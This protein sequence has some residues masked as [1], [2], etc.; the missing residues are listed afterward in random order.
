MSLSTQQQAKL[1]QINQAKQIHHSELIQSLWGGYGELLRVHFKQGLRSSLVVKNIRYPEQVEHPRGWNTQGSHQRKVR[2]YQVELAWYQHF[3]A[4]CDNNCYVPSLLDLSAD[5]NQQWLVLEDLH[6]LGFNQVKQQVSAEQALVCV[7]WLAYFHARFLQAPAAQ[8]WQQGSYWH[9]AT[10]PDEL[11]AMEDSPLKQAA[12]VIDQQLQNSDYHCLIHGDAK[13]ANFCFNQEM[14][15]AAA[16]DFQYVGKGCGIQDLALFM[17]S[18][19]SEQQCFEQQDHFLEIYFHQL[20]Q[21]ISHYKISLVNVAE[22]ERQWRAL[23]PFAWADFQRF[24]LGWSPDHWK[25]NSYSEQQT[26]RALKALA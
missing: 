17:G 19:L 3:A 5:N 13:L 11:A 9:L 22:L 1:C 12:T 7:R 15:Q 8:L 25:L 6:T 23:Y 20:K 24:L 21:A 16:V 2:S 26:Q 14:N 18:C 4:A 10:R